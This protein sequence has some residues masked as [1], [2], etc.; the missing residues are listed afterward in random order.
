MWL[1]TFLLGERWIFP[2]LDSE[3][4]PVPVWLFFPSCLIP[5]LYPLFSPLLLLLLTPSLLLQP[6]SYICLSFST[7]FTLLQIFLA[8]PLS[9]CVDSNCSKSRTFFS[10]SSY[11]L[12]QPILQN[13]SSYMIHSPYN[14]YFLI[15]DS[16]FPSPPPSIG[17]QKF[18]V[19]IKQDDF[20]C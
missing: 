5:M 12:S 1:P 2:F 9:L 13:I 20:R 8:N 19:G 4:C 6:A 11:T 15:L 7:I 18:L 10:S 17:K 3:I 14:I 16:S